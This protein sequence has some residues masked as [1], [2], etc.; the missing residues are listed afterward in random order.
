MSLLHGEP[1]QNATITGD[2][3]LRVFVVSVDCLLKFLWANAMN[4]WTMNLPVFAVPSQAVNA[5]F[6]LSIVAAKQLKV[7]CVWKPVL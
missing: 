2:I 5:V 3:P 6:T 1:I 7:D 4:E